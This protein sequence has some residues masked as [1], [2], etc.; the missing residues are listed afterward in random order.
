MGF[1]FKLMILAGVLIGGAYFYGDAQPREHRASRTVTLVAATDT[2]Y[3]LVRNIGAYPM[4]WDDAVSSARVTGQRR[5]TW[6]Q[7]IKRRGVIRTQVTSETPGARL[8][9]TVAND[10]Q[11][12]FGGSWTVT[13]RLTGSGTEVTILEHWWIEK[14]LSRTHAKLNGAP[15]SV[16]DSFLKSL[17]VNF[18]EMAQPRPAAAR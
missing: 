14:P 2:V 1:L 13:V 8:V 17:A 7:E 4:W 11:Q 9:T 10:E 15:N 5:E 18:G 6:E 16:M 3:R 12:D